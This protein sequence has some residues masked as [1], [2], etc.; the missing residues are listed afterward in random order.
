MKLILASSSSSRKAL[1]ARL[2]LPFTAIHPD[3]DES[4]LPNEKPDALALRLAEAKARKMA[5]TYPNAIIIGSDQVI[6][7]GDTRLDKPGNHENA[8]AQLK[9]VSEKTIQ[10]YTGLCVLNTKTNYLQKQIET[11]GVSFRKLTD[12]II[13]H[14]LNL[15]EPWHAAGSIKAE[16]LG[17]VLFTE[18]KGRDYTALLGLPLIL[19]TDMLLNEHISPLMKPL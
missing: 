2:Q 9:L 12:Q 8:R 6:M 7:C 17:I 15:D 10:S 14:Y 11:F 3:I 19:L 16:S 5:D 18:M 4:P 13:E 1:F